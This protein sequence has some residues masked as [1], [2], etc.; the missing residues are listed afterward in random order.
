[1]IGLDSG[2]KLGRCFAGRNVL[3]GSMMALR[4]EDLASYFDRIGYTG[5]RRPDL[6]TL[7]GVVAAHAT[8]IPFENIDVLLGRGVR[9]ERPL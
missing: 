3:P 9:L 4:D 8:S 5:P 1:M 2:E 7:R 6:P